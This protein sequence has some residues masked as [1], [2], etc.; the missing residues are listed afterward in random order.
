MGQD[1]AWLILWLNWGREGKGMLAGVGS[2][3]NG[4]YLILF[5]YL[6]PPHSLSLFRRVL[7]IWLTQIQGLWSRRLT[8]V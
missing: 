7:A 8:E 6:Q 3:G 2:S 4:V 5:P 1:L